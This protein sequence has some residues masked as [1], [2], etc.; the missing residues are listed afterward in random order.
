MEIIEYI[1][2]YITPYIAVVVF[3][4]GIA[5]QIYRWR[6]AKPVN[7]HLSLFP[8]P[9]NRSGRLADALVEMFTLHGLFRVNTDL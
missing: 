9:E 8:R 4:G 1:L 2:S 5:Y 6:Q 3:F 7:A